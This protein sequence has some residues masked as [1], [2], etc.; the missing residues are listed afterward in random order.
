[1]ILQHVV[2]RGDARCRQHPFRHVRLSILF[3]F[4]VVMVA[5]ALVTLYLYAEDGVCLVPVSVESALA[6]LRSSLPISQR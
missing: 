5:V 3:P 6:Q 2:E 1:M 4:D